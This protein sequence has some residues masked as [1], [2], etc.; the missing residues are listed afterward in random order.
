MLSVIKK[1]PRKRSF[2][3]GIKVSKSSRLTTELLSIHVRLG[4]RIEISL[5][6]RLKRSYLFMIGLWNTKL[7]KHCLP[8]WESHAVPLDPSRDHLTTCSRQH[9]NSDRSWTYV[10][11]AIQLGVRSASSAVRR[12]RPQV[13][14]SEVIETASSRDTNMHWDKY[15]VT[16]VRTCAIT[17][18]ILFGWGVRII[19]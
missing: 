7:N 11:L 10:A 2:Q 14:A 6:M 9:P 18:T 19:P 15:C 17:C 5:L 8:R 1:L 3:A 4:S 13:T 16:A 12:D